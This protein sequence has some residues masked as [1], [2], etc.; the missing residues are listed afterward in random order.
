[1][2]NKEFRAPD[3]LIEQRRNDRRAETEKYID[4]HLGI[5]ITR[6]VLE[7]EYLTSK[8]VDLPKNMPDR[9][10]MLVRSIGFDMVRVAAYSYL[11]YRIGEHFN[12]S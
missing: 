10:M 11:L 12:K 9:T 4:K 7:P 3:E 5:F 2:T 1:M 6:G 8:I